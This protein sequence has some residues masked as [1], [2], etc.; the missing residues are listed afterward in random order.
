MTSSHGNERTHRHSTDI[1]RLDDRSVGL[2]AIFFILMLLSTYFTY[3]RTMASKDFEVVSEDTN[4]DAS[5]L[6]DG[7]H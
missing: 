3:A 4:P 2:I 7:F 6:T 1:Q 5:L